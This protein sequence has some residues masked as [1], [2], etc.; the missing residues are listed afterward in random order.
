MLNSLKH[1]LFTVHLQIQLLFFYLCTVT[2]FVFHCIFIVYCY[3]LYFYIF[4]LCT[5]INSLF[6]FEVKTSLAA[7]WQGKILWVDVI[8]MVVAH[9]STRIEELM[10]W[11][12]IFIHKHAHHIMNF[13]IPPE[14]SLIKKYVSRPPDSSS[15]APTSNTA[16][17]DVTLQS[18]WIENG[19]NIAR[20]NCLQVSKLPKLEVTDL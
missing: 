20:N 19:L 9:A 13:E 17:R 16:M 14:S 12:K 8:N 4:S 2:N 15:I 7:F 3:K 6:L 10:I 18:I 11:E 1:C 5:I